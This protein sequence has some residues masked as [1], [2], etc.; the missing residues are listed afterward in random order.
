MRRT[1][2][3]SYVRMRW[4]LAPSCVTVGTPEEEIEMLAESTERS[5]PFTSNRALTELVQSRQQ[6]DGARRSLELA[7]EI[8]RGLAMTPVPLS[9][10]QEVLAQMERAEATLWEA[11]Q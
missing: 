5:I 10:L 2:W 7:L 3:I 8:F 4:C 6:L 1:T 9:P 11:A